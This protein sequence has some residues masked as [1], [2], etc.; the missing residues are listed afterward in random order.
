MGRW[1]A[2][3]GWSRRL[4]LIALAI[5]TVAQFVQAVGPAS[6]F[7]DMG[8]GFWVGGLALLVAVVAAFGRKSIARGVA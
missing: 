8:Q 2:S 1:W 4:L 6:G 5:L 3:L 7:R